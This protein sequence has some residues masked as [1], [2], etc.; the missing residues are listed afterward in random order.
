MR[1]TGP[2]ELLESF[3]SAVVDVAGMSA[4]QKAEV[5]I[6]LAKPAGVDDATLR[7]A[8]LR[9]LGPDAVEHPYFYWTPRP[10]FSPGEAVRVVVGAPQA[11]GRRGRV[12]AVEDV[13]RYGVRGMAR[14]TTYTVLLE[15][16]ADPWGFREDQLEGAAPA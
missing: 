13:R 6:N 14:A 3:L 9:G 7:D 10:R 4:E 11:L 2:T 1:Q 12:A 15:G 8:L 16:F 5:V